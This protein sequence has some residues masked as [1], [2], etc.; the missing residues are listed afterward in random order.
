MLTIPYELLSIRIRINCFLIL[1]IFLPVFLV[2]CSKVNIIKP[3][4]GAAF[5]SGQ[6]IQFEGEITRSI[7]TGGADRSDDLS[8]DS[9]IDGHIGDGRMLTINRLSVGSHGITASWPNHNRS[10]GI[11]IL[12]N[13]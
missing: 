9:S 1:F 6:A 12:V 13:P 8:W 2:S 7:E 5:T 11:S 4:N 10:D 3:V